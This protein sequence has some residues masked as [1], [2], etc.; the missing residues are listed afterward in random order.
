ME[1]LDIIIMMDIMMEAITITIIIMAIIMTIPN[2]IIKGLSTTLGDPNI[3]EVAEA[4]EAVIITT[5]TKCNYIISV[6]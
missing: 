5:N 4:M 6:N 3:M 2:I 1:V